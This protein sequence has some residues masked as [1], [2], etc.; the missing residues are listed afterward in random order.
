MLGFGSNLGHI[1]NFVKCSLWPFLFTYFDLL[2]SKIVS[3]FQEQSKQAFLTKFLPHFGILGC[4]SRKCIPSLRH[5]NT[6]LVSSRVSLISWG[7]GASLVLVDHPSSDGITM[8]ILY[9]VDVL[10]NQPTSHP[11]FSYWLG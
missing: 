7:E 9:G 4:F 8:K 2:S 3:R 11:I 1:W 10:L 5:W 6:G